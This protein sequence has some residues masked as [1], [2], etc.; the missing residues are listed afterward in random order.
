MRENLAKSLRYGQL[1]DIMYVSKCGQ[2]TKRRL[3]VLRFEGDIFQAFCFLRQ[4]KRTFIIS[5]VLALIPVEH[6]ENGII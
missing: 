5:N 6:R 3:K 2:I 4:T 1:V